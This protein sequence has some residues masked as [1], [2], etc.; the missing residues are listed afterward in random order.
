MAGRLDFATGLM[1]PSAPPQRVTQACSGLQCKRAVS[2]SWAPRFDYALRSDPPTK[3]MEEMAEGIR[4]CRCAKATRA[5]CAHAELNTT[6]APGQD[7]AGMRM[8]V[9]DRE[10]SRF[11]TY[12]CSSLLEIQNRGIPLVCC[13]P[14]P[15]PSWQNDETLPESGQLHL[16]ACSSGRDATKP[17]AAPSAPGQRMLW[18]QRGPPR[19]LEKCSPRPRHAVRPKR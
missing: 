11:M 18:R 2:R 14:F 13:T 7:A 19:G 8:R 9:R 4:Q 10:H 6:G 17:A 12:M 5:M 3:L 15:P 1:R 16:P